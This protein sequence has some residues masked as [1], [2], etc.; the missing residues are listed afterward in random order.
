MMRDQDVVEF[1]TKREEARK[2][3][4]NGVPYIGDTIIETYRF[5]NM[6]REDDRVTIWI[7]DNWREPNNL[8]PDLWFA[9]AV[10]RMA[11]N[12]IDSM[13]DLGYPVPWDPDKF[14]NM[15]AMRQSKNLKI[16][17]PAYMIATPN[18]SGPKQDFLV[19]KLLNPMWENRA[20]IRPTKN[21]TL[22]SFHKKLLSCYGVGSFTGAQVV[23]DMKYTPILKNASDWWTWAA[24][25]PGSQRGLN[26]VF[27]RNKNDA[28]MADD[29]LLHLQKLLKEVNKHFKDEPFHAQDLQNV[30][31]E[32]DKYERAK[33]N[34]GKPKQK[35]TP[36][37]E[38]L[39]DLFFD[40]EK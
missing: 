7:N 16:Y 4:L 39:F 36:F 25:G 5:C 15:V 6:R 18:W 37:V 26:R 31:C 28:W 24:P 32:F 29:W 13:S 21:D 17:N 23:A 33:N 10:A 3:K 30:M 38:N 40:E 1:I 12:N 20:K 11:L 9:M 34:E 22:E 8:D 14:L 2:A 19:Q 27:G 35:Y